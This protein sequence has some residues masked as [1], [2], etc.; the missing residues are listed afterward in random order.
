MK[1]LALEGDPTR[2]LSELA[3][4]EKADLVVVGSRGEG[5]LEAL[6]LGSVARGISNDTH[7]NSLTC[8]QKEFA[9]SS[10]LKVIFATDHSEFSTK[11]AAKLPELVEGTFAQLSIVSI[12]DSKTANMLASADKS[13][14]SALADATS[15]VAAKLG[16]LAEAVDSESDIGDPREEL[17]RRSN[18][19]DLIILGAKSPSGFSRLLLGSVSHY[20]LTRSSCSVMIVRP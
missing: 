18:D 7:V 16:V 15:D 19:A 2:A 13:I 20:V 12:L 8:R 14:E 4:R 11:V 9:L 3:E 17:L 1:A 5:T 6:F 10:G